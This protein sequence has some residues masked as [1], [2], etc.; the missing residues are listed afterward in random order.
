MTVRNATFA[1]L[2]EILEI[3]AR[4]RLF[5]QE[6]GNP[7]QWGSIYPPAETVRTDISSR[8]L[9]LLTDGKEI[10][11]VFAFFPDG[12]SVYD[13][14]DG[15]WLNSLPHAAIHR[16]ASA[17]KCHGVLANIVEYCG[18]VS[19]NLKIDTHPDNKIMQHS[20]EKLGFVRC[21]VVVYPDVGERIAYQ[22]YFG[23]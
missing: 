17:G 1:D 10:H 2:T 14:I 23:E 7:D 21:G 9:F 6:T 18:Q 3:Y 13:R 19:K 22:K 15:A 11:G 16:V 12:D 5:M 20:L 4:A 8:S